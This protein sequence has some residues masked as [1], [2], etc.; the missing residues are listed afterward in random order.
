ML[1]IR[2]FHK[3]KIS[4]NREDPV[5]SPEEMQIQ[6]RNKLLVSSSDTRASAARTFYSSR[7]Q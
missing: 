1:E 7:N 4:E 3:Q 2:Y 5:V 6:A